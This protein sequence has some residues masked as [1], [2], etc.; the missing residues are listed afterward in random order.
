[1]TST[2]AISTVNR[3]KIMNLQDR[4][5]EYCQIK[6]AAEECPETFETWLKTM[7]KLRPALADQYPHYYKQLPEKVSHL[8][9]YRVLDSFG[10]KRSTVQHA[11]KKLLVTGGRGSK[12]E[13]QDL[14]EAKASI[15]R[16]LE[17]IQEETQEDQEQVEQ[18]PDVAFNGSTVN[19]L[20]AYP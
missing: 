1:M 3:N 2:V 20:L 7:T 5:I 12:N 8:D 17:M 11:I 13:V 18:A 14:L 19:S 4:Y 16:A 9:V 10:V 6:E 15:E